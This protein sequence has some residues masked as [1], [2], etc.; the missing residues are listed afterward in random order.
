[1]TRVLGDNIGRFPKHINYFSV[2]M[3]TRARLGGPVCRFYE[4]DDRAAAVGHAPIRAVSV[5]LITLLLGFFETRGPNDTATGLVRLHRVCQRGC[6]RKTEDRLQHL[7]HVIKCVLI[8]IKNDDVIEFAQLV[9]RGRAR[10]GLYDGS[11]HCRS[12]RK[13]G[14][15]MMNH[16]W[17]IIIIVLE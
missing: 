8:V 7:N 5:N 15:V 17:F 3:F 16:M 14:D 2:L 4:R 13:Y 12:V 1:M 9:F 11:R 6:V 10:F